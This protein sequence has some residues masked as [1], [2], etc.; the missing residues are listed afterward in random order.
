[1]TNIQ[2]T[3]LVFQYKRSEYLKTK[4]SRQY[5]LW[6][7]PYYR[8]AVDAHQQKVLEILENNLS[9]SA[10]VRY[11][12]PNFHTIQ[13]I[14]LNRQNRAIAK[15]SGYVSPSKLKGHY[16]W[17]FT[18]PGSWGKANVFRG[19]YETFEKLETLINKLQRLSTDDLKN[20]ITKTANGFLDT[21]NELNL[22]YT[23]RDKSK[24]EQIEFLLN[25]LQSDDNSL[26]SGAE[27]E[28]IL[29][30]LRIIE[31]SKIFL[32]VDWKLCLFSLD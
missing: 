22:Y 25:L 16:Y 14:A 11:A 27:N 10:L 5:H 3:S 13:E 24:S 2:S 17:T 28:E 26:I 7:R 23:E 21:L 1:M 12:A 31:Y 29:K 32:N 18:T 9:K 15:E 19:E 8:F 30:S 4:N 6:N 20:T